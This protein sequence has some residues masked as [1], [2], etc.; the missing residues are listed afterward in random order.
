M[1][2]LLVVAPLL[3]DGGQLPAV[4]EDQREDEEHDGQHAG[5]PA[6][7]PAA[8]HLKG[9][10]RA[11]GDALPAE[12]TVYVAHLVEVVD[13][14]MVGALLLA[15]AAE[16]AV[17]LV[18]RDGQQREEAAAQLDHLDQVAAA[19][20]DGQ[21]PHPAVRHA[22]V[23]QQ[24]GAGQHDD[25]EGGELEEVAH[26]AQRADV[27][28]PEHAD[29]H[30]AQKEQGDR[31]AGHP[32]D[33]L[34]FEARSQGV[35]GVE[36]LA[37]ELARRDGIVEDHEQQHVLHDAQQPVGDRTRAQVGLHAEFAAQLAEPLAHRS[38]RA[39]VAAE[40]L[41]E[42]DDAHAQHDTHH[43]LEHRHGAG[44]RMPLQVGGQGLQTAERAVSL[45]IDGLLSPTGMENRPHD[46]RQHA[47][48]QQV[49]Q[50]IRMFL[51]FH[52]VIILEFTHKGK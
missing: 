50:V 43:D 6:Q 20:G 25:E 7:A 46:R 52:R 39:E 2:D 31:G 22:Q 24:P 38:Q 14:D 18:A 48:L 1:L 11:G 15:E 29:E 35:V 33:D 17:M 34:P 21:S 12:G 26:R 44:Q 47:P 28:A 27:A 16:I 8:V 4:A 37:E 19:A 41:A 13:I 32:E 3:V 5:Q 36:A 45:D 51:R 49:F 40:E 9:S 30:A 23:A 42:E 10:G